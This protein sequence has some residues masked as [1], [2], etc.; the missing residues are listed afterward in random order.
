MKVELQCGDKITI[1]EGC[2]AIVKGKSVVFEKEE[3]VQELKDGDVLVVV[4]NGGKAQ[5]FYL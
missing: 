5:C 4:V 3:K 2:K 1:P